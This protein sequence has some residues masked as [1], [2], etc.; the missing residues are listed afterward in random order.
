MGGLLIFFG[1]Y[2][3]IPLKIGNG[4][5]PMISAMPGIIVL[6][7]RR[8]AWSL[9][10]VSFI[11]IPSISFLLLSF[12]SFD[13]FSYIPLRFN[14]SAQFAYSLLIGYIASNVLI[15]FGRARVHATAKILIIIFLFLI[16]LELFTPFREIVQYYLSLYSREYNFFAMAD[17]E[18]NMGGYRP[19]L[20]TSETSYVAMTAVLLVTTYVWTGERPRRYKIA[21]FV[22]ALMVV[23]I[24]SPIVF[25]SIPIILVTSISDR[26]IGNIRYIYALSIMVFAVL[27]GT[28]LMTIGS[29][30]IENRLDRISSGADYSTT[31]RTYGAFAVGWNV[32]TE[33][34][35]FGVGPG[36]LDP[37]RDIIMETQLGLGVP[38]TAVVS[39]WEISINNAFGA[40]LV[41]FGFLGSAIIVFTAAVFIFGNLK[42]S[43]LP[44]V[45]AILFLSATSGSIYTPKFAATFIIIVAAAKLRERP[46]RQSIYANPKSRGRPAAA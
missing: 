10:L 45:S 7:L 43:R 4:T 23:L 29:R 11:V 30:V 17:R 21:T 28:V 15:D 22:T 25:L 36:G 37:A 1:I 6:L 18:N 31:Y 40:V 20:F 46:L 32:A 9:R 24:R 2:T 35:A 42:P 19:K 39:N 14:A 13:S 8:N 12:L 44:A 16:I 5:V 26:S 41:Y 34:P 27:I 3:D 38:E 33:F